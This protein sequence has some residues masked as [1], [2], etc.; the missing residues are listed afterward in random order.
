MAECKELL[1]QPTE[2]DVTESAELQAFLY[3]PVNIIIIGKT[4]SGKSTLINNIFAEDVVKAGHSL[5]RGTESVTPIKGEVDGFHVTIYDTP[6]LEDKDT[7]AE[8]RHLAQIEDLINREDIHLAILC[9]SMKETRVEGSHLRTLKQY[10]KKGLNLENSV[11][12]LTFADEYHLKPQWKHK[13]AQLFPKKV[14]EWKKEIKETLIQTGLSSTA[15]HEVNNRIYPTTYTYEEKSPS[16]DDWYADL[17]YGILKT[18]N[19]NAQ[20]QFLAIHL[21]H[22]DWGD[23]DKHK[24]L[25]TGV[26]S[27]RKK[28]D[29]V[30][31]TRKEEQH[32]DNSTDSKEHDDDEG[33]HPQPRIPYREA[34]WAHV[35]DLGNFIFKIGSEVGH[36]IA[37]L[38][39]FA[40]RKPQ[41]IVRNLIGTFRK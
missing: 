24:E 18:L 41:D 39:Q 4:G 2:G 37:R 5:K 28:K 33:P 19:I 3:K 9:I 23:G 10:S 26:V 14:E 21:K 15:A 30:D 16:G 22:I 7:E 38:I 40:Y 6:G 8:K 31:G 27:R 20:R 17:W 11:I 36:G 25:E 34:L 1:E 29:N 12:A 32:E 13:R 35:K